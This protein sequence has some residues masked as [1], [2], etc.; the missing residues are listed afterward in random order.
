MGGNPKLVISSATIIGLVAVLAVAG[1][2][3][4]QTWVPYVDDPQTEHV[5]N[6]D[7]GAGAGLWVHGDHAYASALNGGVNIF[8]VSEPSAPTL[9]G[10]V[11]AYSR[12]VDILETGDRTIAVTAAGWTNVHVIDVTDPA[13]PWLIES[14]DLGTITHN[15][16]VVQDEDLVYNS[17]SG[18]SGIDI[19]DLSDPDNPEVVKVWRQGGV[20]CHDIAVYPD[21]DR[22]YCAGLS[23]TYIMDIEDPLNPE[24]LTT[25]D[26]DQIDLHH[27]ALA[28]PDQETVIIGDED[29]SEPDGCGE[30]IDTPVANVGAENGALWF[31]DVSLP[32]EPVRKGTVGMPGGDDGWCTSHFGEIIDGAP[33]LAVGWY[34]AGVSIIDWGDPGLPR[35]VDHL[36]LDGNN[37]WDVRHHDGHL[38]TGDLNR[39][40]DVL[41]LEPLLSPIP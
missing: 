5:T 19:I 25:I 9:V 22:A 29:F 27:W 28:S 18:P 36:D 34:T 31:Y 2:G 4:S 40:M 10:H 33:L 38:Y 14:V 17:R 7:H 32:T 13:D 1:A 35:I 11:D 20:T 6:A 15:I 30:A 3:A 41:S 23:E 37:V 8:D 26:E 21:A 24:V 12:D 16:A 39:G